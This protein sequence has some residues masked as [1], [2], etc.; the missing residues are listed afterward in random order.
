MKKIRSLLKMT[1]EERMVLTTILSLSGGVILAAGKIVAGLFSDLIL[2][3]LGVFNL[4]LILAKLQC[5]IGIKKGENN[6]Y[7]RNLSVAVLLFIAGVVY[8]AYVVSDLFFAYPDKV[9]TRFTSIAITA[10]AFL[11]MGLAIRGLVKTKYRGHYYRDI[12]IISLISAMTAMMTAQIALLSFFSEEDMSVYN[13]YVGIAVGVITLLLAIYVYF[14]PEISLS[15]RSHQVFRL[16]NA[17]VSFLPDGEI[18]LVS[19]RIYGDY[20]FRFERKNNLL[21]GDIVRKPGLLRRMP[22]GAKIVCAVLSEI[23]I[24]VWLIGYFVTFF[25]TLNLPLKLQKRMEESGFEKIEESEKEA[26]TKG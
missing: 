6:F 3:A 21:E 8:I 10:I 19:S 13:S 20:V 9:Y 24:F 26:L 18:L 4:L 11:E 17:N 12:K 16:R 7:A 5:L 23:L 15:D 1:Y 22:L 25:R 2:F 14:A